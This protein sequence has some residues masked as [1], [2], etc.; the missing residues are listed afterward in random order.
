[1]PRFSECG[2]NSL[3]QINWIELLA[4]FFAV[5]SCTPIEEDNKRNGPAKFFVFYTKYVL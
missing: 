3:R 4:N 5:L 1:M 2:N